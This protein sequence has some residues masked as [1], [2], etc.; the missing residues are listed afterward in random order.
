M[1]CAKLAPVNAS[2]TITGAARIA[3]DVGAVGM[4]TPKGVKCRYTA[5][6]AQALCR[7]KAI[8]HLELALKVLERL[9]W[10]CD[11]YSQGG[12]QFP[13]GGIARERLVYSNER[14][15]VS[16]SGVTPGPTV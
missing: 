12:V 16:R 15:R 6:I 14:P 2:H 13:T 9:R 1:L 11:Q 5:L 8:S 10:R 4:H 7:T 3:K